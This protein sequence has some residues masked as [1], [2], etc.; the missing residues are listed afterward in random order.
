M[1]VQSVQVSPALWRVCW[2]QVVQRWAELRGFRTCWSAC[3]CPLVSCSLLLSALLLCSR[4][5]ACEYAFICVFKAV[6]GAVWG[7][8]VGLCCLD[9]LR[10]LWGFCTRVELGG[11]KACGVFAPVLSLFPCVCLSFTCFA[12]VVFCLFSL[13]CLC[14]LCVLVALVV[15]SFSLSDYTRK[16]RAQSVFFESSLRVL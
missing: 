7:I 12:L 4:C 16:E 15:V 2:W 8:R 9:T 1:W 10:G 14:S 6:F 5:I 3:A 11:L 13:V